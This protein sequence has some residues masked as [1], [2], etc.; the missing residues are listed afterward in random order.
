MIYIEWIH[1]SKLMVRQQI[2]PENI[3]AKNIP[4]MIPIKTG[5]NDVYLKNGKEILWSWRV[6]FFDNKIRMDFHWK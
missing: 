4:W 1:N 2:K 5:Y 3:N 6:N